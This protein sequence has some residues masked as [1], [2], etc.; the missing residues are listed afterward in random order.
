MID[1]RIAQRRRQ[2]REQRRQHRLRRTV[3]LI[4]LV[5]LA[6]AFVVVER[7]DLVAL[8]EV[9]VI[10]TERLEVDEV[11]AAA[12]L[13]LGTST[14]RLRLGDAEARVEALPLV[15]DA[16]ARRLDPLTVQIEVAE[17]VP[18]VNVSGDGEQVMVDRDGVVTE[19]GHLDGLPE[20]VVAGTPPPP[21]EAVDALPALANAHRAWRALS[22]PLRTEVVRYRADGADE[23]DLELASGVLVHFGRAERVDEKVR[24]LGAVLEDLDGTPVDSIDVRAPSAP[25]ITP[26]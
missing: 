23:L 21:G 16:T 1:E 18:A 3:T 10:G 6:I 19:P 22:G 11:I 7:S 9:E 17:R 25:V 4:V 24:A 13:P 8:E 15:R 14:L 12:D 2:V 20:I 5:V 26:P